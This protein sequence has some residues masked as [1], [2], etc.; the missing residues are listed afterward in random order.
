MP[1]RPGGGRIAGAS[2]Q[3]GKSASRQVGKSASRQV[4]KSASR[5][6]GKSASRQVG[7]SASRQVGKSASRQVG[8]SASRQTRTIGTPK[9]PAFA[10][11]R[12]RAGRRRAR[13][14]VSSPPAPPRETA[15]AAA[16]IPLRGPAAPRAR[17]EPVPAR[18]GA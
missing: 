7:K 3:V 12:A 17:R 2:R 1:T 15:P 8:K 6:V 13:A 5:Q 14:P 9:V 10:H 11:S 16:G 18:R 4:G